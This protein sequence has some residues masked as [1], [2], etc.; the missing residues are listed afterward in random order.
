MARRVPWVGISK[1]GRFADSERNDSINNVGILH[2]QAL[3][4][5]ESVEPRTLSAKATGAYLLDVA[6]L[7]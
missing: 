4:Q 5:N 7:I 3:V 2:S 6:S 1:V